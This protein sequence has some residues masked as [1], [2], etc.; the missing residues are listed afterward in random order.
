MPIYQFY[1]SKDASA[2]S[3]EEYGKIHQ[4]IADNA[5][6]TTSIAM[7]TSSNGNSFRVTGPLWGASTGH[8]WI[9][10]KPMVAC[11]LLEFN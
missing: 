3:H 2:I 6:E 7:M 8:R 10:S 4:L 9:E 1:S 5:R 11:H